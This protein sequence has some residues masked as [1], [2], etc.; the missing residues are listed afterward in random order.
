MSKDRDLERLNEFL[1]PEGSKV[2]EA[3]VRAIAPWIE[4]HPAAVVIGLTTVLCWMLDAKL[5]GANLKN[6][7]QT[8]PD[9]AAAERFRAS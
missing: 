9:Q 4:T 2:P 7:S 6:T 1:S 8:D 3:T 5:S